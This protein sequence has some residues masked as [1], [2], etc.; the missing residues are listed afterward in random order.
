MNFQYQFNQVDRSYLD[1]SLFISNPAAAYTNSSYRGSTHF[2]EFFVNHTFR[3]WEL[4]TGI[5]FRQH[6]TVQDYFSIGAWG[7]FILPTLKA[8]MSQISGYASLQFRKNN[9]TT[10]LG[11]RINQHSVYGTNGTFTFNPAYRLS[12][13]VRVFGNWYTAF[14]T[15]TLFQLYD[16]FAGNSNL[17]PEKGLIQELGFDWTSSQSFQT[18]VVAFH[19][20]S[21]E[22]IIYSYDPMG[23]LGKYQNASRQTNYGVEVEATWNIRPIQFRANYAFTDGRTTGSYDGT[24]APLGKDS[25]YFNLYR[26]PRHAL[27]WQASFQKNQW[28]IQLS[29]RVAS[30]REEFI[31]G[32]PPITMKGYATIDVYTEYRTKKKGLRFFVDLRNLT[33]TR[34]E[35]IRGYNARGF[36]AIAGILWGR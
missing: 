22:T 8:N 33:N 34:Y 17:T 6:S 18:R 30:A 25:S 13:R 27:N 32:A 28:T 29:G 11:G 21:R 7:P 24:G 2:A 1:D 20:N 26:I 5:D 36:T 12:E 19:R 31:F 16:P 14:K 4:L 15:P 3:Q 9:F 10:E 35:E 23:W